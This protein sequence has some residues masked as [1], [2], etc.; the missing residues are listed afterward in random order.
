MMND[1]KNQNCLHKRYAFQI[2]LKT[3]E[4]LMALPSLVDVKVPNGKHFAVMYMVSSLISHVVNEKI[5]VVHGGLFS[6]NG[7]K[8]SQIKAIDHFCEP[9]EE[10]FLFGIFLDA[11]VTTP[12][13]NYEAVHA[14]SFGIFH[15]YKDVMASRN[16]A[17]C[18]DKASLECF[19]RPSTKKTLVFLNLLFQ[20]SVKTFRGIGIGI[21]TSSLHACY[22]PSPSSLSSILLFVSSLSY[23]VASVMQLRDFVAVA[24][25]RRAVTKIKIELRKELVY[26]ICKML[27]AMRSGR[28][29][30]QHFQSTFRPTSGL[31]SMFTLQPIKLPH[32]QYFVL[33]MSYM[34]IGCSV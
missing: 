17:S 29:P 28:K 22:L 5:F 24:K 21:C 23:V 30:T 3:R 34:S 1:F 6:T 12:C 31:F 14:A 9:P 32:M 18:G 16:L 7:M 20:P 13:Q 26:L 2:V 4:I 8:L 25:A 10:D 19:S 27:S 15:M 11:A 33:Q